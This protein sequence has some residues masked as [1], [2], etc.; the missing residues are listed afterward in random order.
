MPNA[1]VSY[2]PYANTQ[3]Q[4]NAWAGAISAALDT[5]GLTRVADTGVIASWGAQTKPSIGTQPHYEI[6]RLAAPQTGAPAV[7]IRLNYGIS[8]SS[9]SYP[10][11]AIATGTGTD[12]AGNLTGPGSTVAAVL[13]TPGLGEQVTRLFYASSDGDGFIMAHAIDSTALMRGYAIVDRQRR[14][15]G[16]AAPN[17]GWPNIGYMRA[18]ATTTFP[19]VLFVDPVSGDLNT[20]T[21]LPAITGRTLATNT[22]MVNSVTEMTMWPVFSPNRQGLYMCKMALV[23][24][25]ADANVTTDLVT[26]FLGASRTYRALGDRFIN[27]DINGSA[28]ATIAMWWSD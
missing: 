7:Y 24:P 28:G 21:K 25:A 4:Y 19:N 16:V 23:Y 10:A 26:S 14:A 13:C 11:L 1:A 9:A 22:S 12:G 5:I 27:Q 20:V 8:S 18:V 3:A 17:S 2:V 6:R 15:D